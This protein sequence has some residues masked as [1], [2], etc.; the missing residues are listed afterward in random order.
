MKL[1]DAYKL[2]KKE[3]IE[4]SM[5]CESCRQVYEWKES[6][7]Y[8]RYQCL[9]CWSLAVI[10]MAEWLENAEYAEYHDLF[11]QKLK[12]KVGKD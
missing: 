8:S 2:L 11:W 5:W 10:P 12:G 9:Y 1:A 7:P 3:Q 4:N 6:D